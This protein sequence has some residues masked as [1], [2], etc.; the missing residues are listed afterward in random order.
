MRGFGTSRERAV[1]HVRGIELY[2][3]KTV[4]VDALFYC[5]LMRLHAALLYF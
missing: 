2:G 1:K 4:I 5:E 3:R